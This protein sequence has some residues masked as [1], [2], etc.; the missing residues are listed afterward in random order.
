MTD[1]YLARPAEVGSQRRVR[2]YDIA[3]RFPLCSADVNLLLSCF[4]HD[5][6][7]VVNQLTVR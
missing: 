6:S 4:P 5:L 2:E 3:T 7:W 1:R